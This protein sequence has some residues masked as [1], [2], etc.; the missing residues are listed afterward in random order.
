VVVGK[1]YSKE[2]RDTIEEDKYD[3]EE[4]NEKLGPRY[5]GLRCMAK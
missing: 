4:G 1:R 3:D 5:T 2:E